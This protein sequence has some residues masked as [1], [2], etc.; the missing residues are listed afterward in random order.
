VRLF[1]ATADA[2]NP[3]CRIL[4]EKLNDCL[5][6]YAQFTKEM[7]EAVI[8]DGK[9]VPSR[10]RLYDNA[11]RLGAGLREEFGVNK[12]TGAMRLARVVYGIVGI[13]FKCG[14]QGDVVVERCFSA[15]TTPRKFAA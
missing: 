2:F 6:M 13:D 1:A 14:P 12:M 4:V 11:Y 8:R 9:Q 7:A 3:K 10:Q 5:A 15:P